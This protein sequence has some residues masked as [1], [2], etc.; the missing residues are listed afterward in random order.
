MTDLPYTEDDLRAEATSQ[1]ATLGEDPDFM[2]VGEQMEDDVVTSTEADGGKT[3]GELLPFEADRGEA[4]NAAQR[5]IH[6]LI[7]GAA[8]VSDWAVNL[9]A[10]GLEPDEHQLGFSAGDRPIVRIHFAFAPELTD[11]ARE[12]LVRGIGEAA[13]REM[14]LARSDR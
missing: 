4:F 14:Y 8:D 12:A 6:D 13:A 5:R 1:L 10:D 7:N 11:D 9:G 2:G 3:W